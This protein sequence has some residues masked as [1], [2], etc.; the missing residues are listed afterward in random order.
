[1]FKF[2]Y[3]SMLYRSAGLPTFFNAHQTARKPI[4]PAC[5]NNFRKKGEQKKRRCSKCVEIKRKI[6]SSVMKE[7]HTTDNEL[8]LL[9][10]RV[11]YYICIVIVLL[12]AQTPAHTRLINH[13]TKT[14]SH[15]QNMR[16][17]R[18]CG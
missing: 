2:V 13:K 16:A 14:K 12:S 17:T 4:K 10:P 7:T 9:F 15:N 18:R 1:M 6:I 8:L 11:A 5:N 3:T